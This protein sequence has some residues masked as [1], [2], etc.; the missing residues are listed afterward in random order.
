MARGRMPKDVRDAPLEKG[1]RFLALQKETR[2]PFLAEYESLLESYRRNLGKL[3]RVI[4][5]SDKYQMQLIETTYKLN[6][7]LAQLNQ[8]KELTLPI[9]MHCKKIRIDEHYWERIES[10]FRQHI[11]V[12]FSH[13]ICPECVKEKYGDI[14]DRTQLRERLLR[15]TSGKAAGRRSHKVPSTDE[16]LKALKPLLDDPALQANPLIGTLREFSEKYRK[17]LVR[18][19]KILVISDS[20]Q[21]QLQELNSILEMSTRTDL[22]TGLSNR[23]DIIERMEGETNRTLRHGT[24]FSLILADIDYFKSVNDRFG[25]IAGD[26]VLADFGAFLRAQTRKED[27]CARWGGEEFMILLPE[28]DEDKAKAVAA[29]LLLLLREH[30]FCCD[31]HEVRLTMSAGIAAFRGDQTLDDCIRKADTALYAA[32]NQG[33]DRFTVAAP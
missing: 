25:H 14:N 13:G 22:L 20:Y 16:T 3:H 5:I 15:E 4:A 18:L 27:T 28:T 30:V 2:H 8:L 31:G 10:Y 21:A 32:K 7:A 23:R 24:T 29:K 6:S 19:N 9:C 11:D 17:L 1:E 26:R 12:V 33:R